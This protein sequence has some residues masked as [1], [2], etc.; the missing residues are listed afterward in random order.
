MKIGLYSLSQSKFL[1]EVIKRNG[2]F[3]NQKYFSYNLVN[4]TFEKHL[5]SDIEELITIQ[6]S[7]YGI[8][9]FN[10]E[11]DSFETINFKKKNR[12]GY[13]GTLNCVGLKGEVVLVTA[14]FD[15]P[16]DIDPKD[17]RFQFENEIM[18]SKENYNFEEDGYIYENQGIKFR[19]VIWHGAKRTIRVFNG[20][21]ELASD[22]CIV[23]HGSISFK[24][25]IFVRKP[26]TKLI[27]YGPDTQINSQKASWELIE[28]DSS[29]NIK[30]L[31]SMICRVSNL[32]LQH[33]HV[34]YYVLNHK[35]MIPSNQIVG[36]LNLNEVLGG[37]HDTR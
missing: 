13:F 17:W 21:Q 26:E 9:L 4:E 10:I 11:F 25:P 1:D 7:C 20:T 12:K 14:R 31:I 34:W 27:E 28:L 16:V 22:E 37:F 36:E 2:A 32:T 23:P 3:N 15:F 33:D 6:K 24:T 18:E 5:K 30:E 19:F 8:K 29:S 35:K